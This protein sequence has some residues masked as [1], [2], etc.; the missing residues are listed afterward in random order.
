MDTGLAFSEQGYFL[1]C[2][3]DLLLSIQ[4]GTPSF[5]T[6]PPVG[7]LPSPRA[8]VGLGGRDGSE[9]REFITLAP[10]L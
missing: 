4:I 5:N 3:G 6:L 9:D 10:S 1:C 7:W 2:A 8:P